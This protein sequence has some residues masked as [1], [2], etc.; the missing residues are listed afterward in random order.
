[1]AMVFPVA[2]VDQQDEAIARE[3]ASST[4]VCACEHELVQ[5]RPHRAEDCTG[6]PIR[7]LIE[8]LRE[9]AEAVE[10]GRVAAGDSIPRSSG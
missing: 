6:L 2:G 10:L 3:R 5:I 8:Y 4:L 1:M 7:T 9:I